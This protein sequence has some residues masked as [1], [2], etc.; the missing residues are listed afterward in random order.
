MSSTDH[1]NET[2]NHTPMKDILCFNQKPPK[3][4][5]SRETPLPVERYE[6]SAHRTGAPFF[7][8]LSG[9]KKQPKRNYLLPDTKE[10]EMVFLT[11]TLWGVF[12]YFKG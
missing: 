11:N 9:L 6:T 10:R 8:I 2:Y 7:A 5:P 4:S 12:V 1:I 3:A